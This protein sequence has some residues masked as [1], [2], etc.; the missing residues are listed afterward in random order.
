[1]K[2]IYFYWL[3]VEMAWLV[4]VLFGTIMSRKFGHQYIHIVE[5]FDLQH[6]L[7]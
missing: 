4:I 2:Q 3:L 7:G 1:M 6:Q 5:E